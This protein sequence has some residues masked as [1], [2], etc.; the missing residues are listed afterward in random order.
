MVIGPGIVNFTFV[1][2]ILRVSYTS[3][4]QPKNMFTSRK[5]K[6]QCLCHKNTQPKRSNSLHSQIARIAHVCPPNPPSC[7][8]LL[9]EQGLCRCSAHLCPTWHQIPCSRK[10]LPAAKLQPPFHLWK[11]SSSNEQHSYPTLSYLVLI[12]II[13]K[14]LV[15][16]KIILK[17]QRSPSSR[18]P[19]SS[20]L[21][22][23]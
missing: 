3:W 21:A 19:Y 4:S 20:Q 15:L 10:L 13:L 1:V 9:K 12:K 2:I 8:S 5:D 11:I 6:I 23:A 16:M 14:Y 17:Y 22:P 18:P 7:S